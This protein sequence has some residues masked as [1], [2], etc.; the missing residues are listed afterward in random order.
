VRLRSVIKF[1]DQTRALVAAGRERP[2]QARNVE[3]NVLTS[4]DSLISARETYILSLDRF[5]VRLG[6]PVQEAV[7]L[8]P[9]TL[10]LADPDIGIN[11]AAE[12][13]LAYRLDY[14]NEADRVDDSRRAVANAR[15]GLLPDL[16]A[17][18]EAALNT[19]PDNR[20]A[21][22]SFDG[23]QT[24]YN[25]SLTLGLPLD[26]EIERLNLRSSIIDLQQQIRTFELFRDNLILDA[27]QSVREI[28]RARFSLRLQEQA[29]KI[30]ELRLQELLIKSAEVDPQTRLDAENE[31]LQSRNDRDNALRDLRI[32]ILQ[33]LLRTGQMRVGGDGRLRPL[34][35]MEIRME[36]VP[37]P[38]VD[39][40]YGGQSSPV[41]GPPPP[42]EPAASDPLDEP[43]MQNP[44][45]DP[46]PPANP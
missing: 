42:G 36:P 31:L 34:R 30:N 25:A 17:A 7:S 35:D 33:Y 26:R 11:Q 46:P 29:V 1:Y 18:A 12:L 21:G 28:D 24:D 19:D 39:D 10:D 6:I 8:A 22:I 37:L 9:M 20:V 15:N 44:A 43:V 13:A 16:N 23:P 27:R 38:S 2:F 4:R 14:Q 41:Q 3:Q 45:P 5:K 32:A 40:M